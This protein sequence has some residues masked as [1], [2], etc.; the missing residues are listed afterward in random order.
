MEYQDSVRKRD[1]D[2]DTE[3]D[4]LEK[5]DAKLG[6]FSDRFEK[7][8]SAILALSSQ[9]S[10]QDKGPVGNGVEPERLDRA[11]KRAQAPSPEWDSD[12]PQAHE[13]NKPTTRSGV[14]E[15]PSKK[16]SGPDSESSS[17]G[18]IL[19]DEEGESENDDC[20]SLDCPD[21]ELLAELEKD[22]DDSEKTSQSVAQSVS[23]IS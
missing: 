2:P 23:G 17:D 13:N 11:K 7:T 16:Q 4:K 22:L 18:E 21:D 3:V 14:R 19:D 10:S 20:I 6:Q 5:F 1:E 12:A 15:P 8:E 9:L